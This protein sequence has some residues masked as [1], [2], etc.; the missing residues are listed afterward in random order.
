MQLSLMSETNTLLIMSETSPVSTARVSNSSCLSE[1]TAAIEEV[2]ANV[3]E[4]KPDAVV[5]QLVH[6]QPIAFDGPVL[7][8]D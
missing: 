3:A 7:V 1:A 2:E 8:S 5:S 6:C 4:L